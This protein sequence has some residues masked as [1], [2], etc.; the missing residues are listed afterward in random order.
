M[1]VERLHLF[2]EF[3]D[4]LYIQE[5]AEAMRVSASVVEK[6]I[7]KGEINSVTIGENKLVLKSNLIKYIEKLCHVCY[8]AS[9]KM[10]LDN[11]TEADTMPYAEETSYMAIKINQAIEINGKRHWIT[12]KTAQEFADKIASL[13][14]DQNSQRMNRHPFEAYAW[15]W[16]YTYSKPTVATVTATTYSRQ[17]K[18]VLIPAFEGLAVEDITP[19]HVQQMFNEMTRTKATKEKVKIVLNQ[20]LEAAIEDKLISTNPLKSRKVKITGAASKT[21]EAYSV[22]Q[23][24]FL[25]EHLADVKN[26]HD[27]AF[28]ALIA[29]HPLRL[30]EV[31][32]LK[33]EDVN[34][35][36]M[37]I[38]IRRA[39]TH[40]NRNQPEVK[41]V[42]T[43]GSARTIA[44][45]ALAMSH[46]PETPAGQYVFGGEKPLS[47]TVVRR[48]CQRIKKDTQFEE[49][50]TPIRFRT[51]VLT[52][53]YDQTK[54]IKLVQA[55]A[56][57]TTSA[58]TLKHYVKGR[59]TNDQG[60]AAIE[61]LYT[62]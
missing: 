45:S 26:G 40:P 18:N 61:K 31:L 17:I 8:D 50:I 6:L 38:T 54:D 57:H 35:E 22:G 60:A 16:F 43:E 1:E 14:G 47:Y 49:N 24:R 48:M 9:T 36:N 2:N 10:H 13:M 59:Q 7:E 12:A 37:T 33:G 53:M 32:G 4:L 34:V 27:R 19:D 42:K 25:I 20:I 3:P 21:T 5:A 44:F 51:T 41:E 30:E 29:L 46:I 15:N 62:A 56:G 55:A 11:Y 39:V 23:M 28:L 58:M 52:D